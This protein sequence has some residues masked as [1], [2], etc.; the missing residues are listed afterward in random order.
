MSLSKELIIRLKSSLEEAV[1]E[2]D[3][4]EFWLAR[5]IHAILDY[6]QYRNF[7]PVIEKAR[8]ACEKSGFEVQDHFADVRKMVQLGS[9]AE[10]EIDDVMLS[11]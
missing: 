4:V 8:L 1:H 3:G 5:E 7:L 11:R 10:R 6:T 2:K 9:G